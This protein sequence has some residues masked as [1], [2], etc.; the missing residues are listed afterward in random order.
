MLES[1][2]QAEPLELALSTLVRKS[3]KIEEVARKVRYSLHLESLIP[4]SG[5]DASICQAIDL[6]ELPAYGY[7]SFQ[8][9]PAARL[10]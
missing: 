5:E 10:P 7:Q 3:A 4:T 8:V 9:V 6:V 1:L 2:A